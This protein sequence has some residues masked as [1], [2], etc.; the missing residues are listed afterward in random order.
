[1]TWKE[2]I[3]WYSDVSQS[4]NHQFYVSAPQTLP[5]QVSVLPNFPCLRSCRSVSQLPINCLIL[6]LFLHLVFG[7]ILCLIQFYL[8]FRMRFLKMYFQLLDIYFGNISV[9]FMLQVL[10]IFRK[11]RE[12]T[13]IL[14]LLLDFIITTAYVITILLPLQFVGKFRNTFRIHLNAHSIST[15][16][17]ASAA[18][19]FDIYLHIHLWLY[20]II[21]VQWLELLYLI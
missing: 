11:I 3:I 17:R 14:L 18:K 8:N 1:M 21:D 10:F 6:S 12:S 13:C 2:E 7:Y 4:Q 15:S 16:L 5:S 9:L 20:F 19:H